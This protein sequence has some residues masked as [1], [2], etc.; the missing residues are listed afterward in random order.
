LTEDEQCPISPFLIGLP[1][2]SH[3]LGEGLWERKRER[4]RPKK[5]RG[6]AIISATGRLFISITNYSIK[7]QSEWGGKEYRRKG[8][9]ETKGFFTE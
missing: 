3:R 8:E 1:R 2:A 4:K 9:G 6:A 5:A 7:G